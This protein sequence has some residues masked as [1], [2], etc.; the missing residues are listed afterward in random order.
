M[1]NSV[2]VNVSE[3]ARSAFSTLDAL[4][5]H[6]AAYHISEGYTAQDR[7][8]TGFFIDLIH[9]FTPKR[10]L[11]IGFNSGHSSV[12]LLSASA[13]GSEV[14]SFDLGEHYYVD[15]A[16]AFVD[17]RFAGRHTLI[18]GNSIE[19]VAKYIAD[20]KGSGSGSGSGAF[21]L[22]FIDGGHYD[23]IPLRDCINCMS[24]A[25]ENTIVVIDDIVITNRARIQRWNHSP[26]YAWYMMCESG[27]VD[28]IGRKEFVDDRPNDGR[29]F[30]WGRFN[31]AKFASEPE[32]RRYK[33]LFKKQNRGTLANTMTH[34]YGLRDRTHLAAAAETFLDYFENDAERET[35]LAK[36]YKGFAL[37]YS[38]TAEAVASYENLLRIPN[39][40][41][42]LKFFTNCNLP[43]LYARP[44]RDE[45]IPKVIHLL[46]FGETEFHNFH[47]RC[48]RSMLFHM[49]DYRVVIYNNVEPTENAFW[50]KLKTHPRVTVEHI[51]VPTHFDGYELA[52]FQYK[53]DV[54]R[55]EI[56]YNRGGV[57]LDL[58]MLIVRNFDEVFRNGRDLYLSREGDGPGLINAFIAAK[59]KNEFLKI[60]LDHFKT[61]LR[62]GVWAYHIRDTNRLLLEKHPYYE[63]KF[64]IE[65][66]NC[67][68]FFPV[69][70]TAR[71]VF[72]GSRKFDFTEKHY[73]VHLFETILFDVVKR[74]DFFNYVQDVNI[75]SQYQPPP[76]LPAAAAAAAAATDTTSAV[77][78]LMK[79]VNE[80]VILTT[81]ERVDRQTAISSHFRSAGLPFTILRNKMHAKPVIGCLEAHMN[82]IRR[83][84]DRNYEAIMICED[85]IV[86]TDRFLNFRADSLPQEW[87]M[88]YLGGI[89]TQTLENG[90][91]EK[92]VRGVIWCNHAYIVKRHMYDKILDYYAS[93]YLKQPTEIKSDGT[94]IEPTLATDHMFT[95]HFH[96]THNCWLAIDQFMVQREDFSNIDQRVKWA[97]NFDW[98]TFTMK[99]I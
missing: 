28:Q 91:T 56:L 95:G 46:Y 30:A 97:N 4:D 26:N 14:V 5:A 99:Y 18:K 29:G 53:A 84:R 70:W 96:K 45:G 44:G 33:M 37:A 35:Q 2:D 34:F 15:H 47:D 64:E 67:E 48:V 19:T 79:I 55:L 8:Q 72:D 50:D 62:M 43:N 24:L 82:A 39:V 9:S 49:R 76:V 63:S 68:K 27:Y 98:N 58:D 87:D 36:F 22:M 81:E 57:Y 78:Q 66:L 80:I 94:V 88:L 52:H 6:M 25:H 7:A 74:N 83:A 89:L 21:D 20:N 17:A 92:W 11:E 41:D 12:S 59:P 69:P 85:D 93:A 65:V 40:A 51:D 77:D 1:T 42:D 38:D 71:D 90:R 54:V 75:D 3:A 32:Y 73:G 60:W 16:K 86:V 23:D 61:G 10:I 31:H 13:P